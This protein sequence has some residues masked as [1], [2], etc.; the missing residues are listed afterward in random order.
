MKKLFLAVIYV[1][2]FIT[3]SAQLPVSESIE[4][5]NLVFID[6]TG[7][8]CTSCP[9]AHKAFE[10]SVKLYKN[11]V[12]VAF[13]H[14]SYAKPKKAGDPELETIAGTK[15]ADSITFLYDK[16]SSYYYSYYRPTVG[17]NGL[18]NDFN[19]MYEY[20][21]QNKI[22]IYF[23]RLKKVADQDAFVNVAGEYSYNETT[24]EIILDLELFYTG[25]AT[26][27]NYLFVYLL[28]NNLMTYQEGGSSNYEQKHIFREALTN[29]WG[30][31][32]GVPTT[33]TKIK[34][35][36]K[37]TL[38]NGYKYSTYPEVPIDAKNIDFAIFVGNKK[39]SQNS[40]GGMSGQAQKNSMK[41][42]AIENGTWAKIKS[43]AAID[44]ITTRELSLY[45]NPFSTTTVLH[46][47]DKLNN[48][49]LTLNNYI[50]QTVKQIK[51]ISGTSVTLSR[52][53]L[54]NG[55][56]FLHIT[57]GNK[58]YSGKLIITN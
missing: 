28:Q 23:D 46:T 25:N 55:L 2:L 10:N 14:G 52:D 38:P 15:I 29:V 21:M 4:K 13:H 40:W 16:D 42:F 12:V 56:Y 43:S 7:I 37:Y 33:G 44:E 19:E 11:Q 5:R 51:N 45:P 9:V 24:K 27:E 49:T 22:G 6:F 34:K 3:A 50:G 30:D 41:F 39:S 48:A 54:P 35:Q 17:T 31:S 26:N 8:Y 58:I 36:F 18:Y 57:E 32:I 20:G 53:E 1:G 47:D